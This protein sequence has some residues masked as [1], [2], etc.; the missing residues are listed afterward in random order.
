M[1][2]SIDA[3]DGNNDTYEDVKCGQEGDTL[4]LTCTRKEDGTGEPEPFLL[5]YAKDAKG[6]LTIK[7][8]RMT[9]PELK[10]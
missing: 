8:V 2:E 1:Q 7:A 9:F 10:S 3:K 5:I 6:H 4:K